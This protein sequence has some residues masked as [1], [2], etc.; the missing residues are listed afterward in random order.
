[1]PKSE[2]I[3][4]RR[5][6][7]LLP[8][9]EITRRLPGL[10]ARASVAVAISIAVKITDLLG[11]FG[12]DPVYTLPIYICLIISVLSE[13]FISNHIYAEKGQSKRF[14]LKVLPA[15]L[16]LIRVSALC[17]EA[18]FKGYFYPN[19]IGGAEYFIVLI[20]AVL[21]SVTLIAVNIPAW[22]GKKRR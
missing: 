18:P 3:R 7:S 8:L 4:G 22:L 11:V 20:Y 19:G 13:V 15:Y 14:W 12:K 9:N 16:M 1:M 2:L 21:F 5:D 6:Y 17:T 10:I